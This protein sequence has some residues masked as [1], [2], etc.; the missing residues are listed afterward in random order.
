MR[1]KRDGRIERQGKRK[2]PSP[3]GGK[4]LR[5]LFAYLGERDLK[6]NDEVMDTLVVPNAVVPQFALPKGRTEAAAS[7]MLGAPPRRGRQQSAGKS[8]GA[9]LAKAAKALTT[10]SRRRGRARAMA[11]TPA[12]AP[13]PG[14]AA[15]WQSIG[16]DHVPNGQTY[17]T[18][19][20][21]VIGRLSAIAVDPG[22]PKHV[23]VGSAGGGIWE[24]RDAGSTW[25]P[26][27]DSLPSLA[28]GA[29]AFHPGNHKIVY[30]GSG[31]GNF[32]ASIG[33]G[34][35]RS[36]DGGTTWSVL[37]A[38]PFVGVGFYDLVVDPVVHST[39]YA[40]TT[41][42][43]YK[44]TNGGSS[45]SLKRSG[46]CW[47]ISVH[48]NG[49]QAE[50]L[51]TF[52]DGLFA[53]TNS[54][55]SFA[56][57]ALPTAPSGP[58]TRLAVDRVTTSPD[59]AYAFGAAGGTAY[60][61]RRAGTSW[62]KIAVPA[63]LSVNQAWYDWLVAATPDSTKQFYVGAIDTLRFDLI[64]TTWRWVNVTT[65]G[66]SSIHPDQHCLTFVPGNSKMIYAGNDGGVYRSANSGG[67]W[68][69]L[70]KGLVITEIEFMAS[71]PNTSKWLMAGTQDN[72]TLRYVG[73]PKWDHIADGDGGDCGVNHLNPNVIYHSYYGV[74]LERSTNKGS[75]WT[76]LAPPSITS[77][78]YPPVEVA[79]TTV[80][81]GAVALV[82]SRTGGTSWTTVPLALAANEMASAMRAVDA[83]TLVIG[84]NRGRMLR[85]TWGGSSW[86]R[87]ALTSPI[88]KHIS[89][90]AVDPSNPQRLWLTSTQ[91]TGAGGRVYRSDNG[92]ISWVNCTAGL[93]A[94][95]INSVSVD[96]ANFKRIWVAADVGVYQSLDL[97]ATWASMAAGLPNAMAVDL[98]FHRQDRRLICGTRNRGAWVIDIP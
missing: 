55:N 72:G 65:R 5:R 26:C 90:I 12:A 61:W 32:Y 33:A 37:A 43:L 89:C 39:L 11:A 71:D 49:G 8:F 44:S 46:R 73:A 67:N 84:T 15:V 91:V 95:P 38:A 97:G 69:A 68:V 77:L 93:P 51:A 87:T 10:R 20:V 85:L 60:L 62:S 88:A 23:L 17:G 6:L 74:S 42:G 35:Y 83:N 54:A 59:V 22:N 70:N 1:G 45:W 86:V 56:A 19:R 48:P 2:A 58:W 64:G 25:Q 13:A 27:S 16:P 92:G 41:V 66:N 14:A 50:L 31:E 47:D 24:T 3:A 52:Q 36:T 4:A 57:V 98:L 78:F 7:R 63:S 94:I 82:V 9:A 96:P 34:V 28:I 80:A 79:G 18:N 53:S 21:D 76:N 81:I 29:V 75:T 40:A 30:A